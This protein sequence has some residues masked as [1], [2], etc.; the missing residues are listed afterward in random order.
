[1]PLPFNYTNVLD[2]GY[3]TAYTKGMKNVGALRELQVT[4]GMTD[5]ELSARAG[6]SRSTLHQMMRGLFTERTLNRVTRTLEAIRIDR[7]DR[8]TKM[9]NVAG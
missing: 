2:R 8:L 7:I 4:L 1:M 6:V 3:R 9:G 5:E